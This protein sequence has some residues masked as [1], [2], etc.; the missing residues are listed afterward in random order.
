MDIIWLLAKLHSIWNKDFKLESLNSSQ[1]ISLDKLFLYIQTTKHVGLFLHKW[2][3]VGRTNTK[4]LYRQVKNTIFTYCEYNF[5]SKQWST[6]NCFSKYYRNNGILSLWLKLY[7]RVHSKSN[8]GCHSLCLKHFSWDVSVT[9]HFELFWDSW[10]AYK[11][12]GKR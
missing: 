4:L 8:R 12:L 10:F 5:H 2:N 1:F 7:D 9:F 3:Q 11:Y 6:F